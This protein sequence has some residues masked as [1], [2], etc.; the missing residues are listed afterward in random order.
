MNKVLKEEPDEIEDGEDTINAEYPKGTTGHSKMSERYLPERLY[1]SI[2]KQFRFCQNRILYFC[3]S[4]SVPTHG[5]LRT[6]S[7]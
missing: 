1:Q 5:R 7:Q 2:L 6:W 4:T 3:I